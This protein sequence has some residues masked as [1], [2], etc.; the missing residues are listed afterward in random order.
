MYG[1]V[2][3]YLYHSWP[4]HCWWKWMVSFMPRP[5]YPRWKSPRYP[6][7]RRLGG[8]WSQ[9]GRCGG[10]NNMLSLPG[11]EPRPSS[12]SLY[13]VCYP[14][15]PSHRSTKLN[16]SRWSSSCAEYAEGHGQSFHVVQRTQELPPWTT[17]ARIPRAPP[18][19]CR[20][21]WISFPLDQRNLDPDSTWTG[22]M[23]SLGMSRV[24]RNTC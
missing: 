16:R 19:P 18:W 4:R 5:L 7:D 9:P 23:E 24:T 15:S 21:A 6:L 13:R 12:P 22:R 11:I 20:S 17:V 1:G 14:G 10:E 3:V 8:S 2:E